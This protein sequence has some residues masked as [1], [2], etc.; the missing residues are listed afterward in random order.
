MNQ[1][2]TELLN[3]WPKMY[4]TS[5][6]VVLILKRSPDAIH[7]LFKRSVD[8]GMLIRVRRDLFLI[9]AKMKNNKPNAFELAPLIY[10]PSYI[11][12]ESALS[13]HGWIPESVPTITCVTTKRTK[14][15]QTPLG[16]FSFK[17]I[18]IEIFHIGIGIIKTDHSTILIAD[19]WKAIADLI[20]LKKR[21]WP[22]ILSFSNDMRIEIDV[23]QYSD[24]IL[25]SKLSNSYPNNRTKLILKKFLKDL[26]K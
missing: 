18:P 22:N 21:S 1:K 5:G 23:L 4:I 17:H 20:Y 26:E 6:D 25:L 9:S 7:S 13:F 11:S 19:S 3:S 2:F 15:I 16:L 14:Q 24:I 8:N 12:C 10:G